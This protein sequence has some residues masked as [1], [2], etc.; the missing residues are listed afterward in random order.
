MNP[1]EYNNN[2]NLLKGIKPI[3]QHE[4]LTPIGKMDVEEQV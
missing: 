2:D 1:Q 4:L 3:E